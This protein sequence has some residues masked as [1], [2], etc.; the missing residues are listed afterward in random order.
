MLLGLSGGGALSPKRRCEGYVFLDV[1]I[2]GFQVRDEQQNESTILVQFEEES[3]P[4]DF[5]ISS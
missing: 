1:D 2:G 3:H 4:I 5:E